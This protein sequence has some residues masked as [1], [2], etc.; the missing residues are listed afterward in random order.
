MNE[1]V[2]EQTKNLDPVIS[3]QDFAL[4]PESTNNFFLH[5]IPNEFG[6]MYRSKK[7]YQRFAAENKDLHQNLLKIFEDFPA[8]IVLGG[9]AGFALSDIETV[10]KNAA[11]RVDF[12]SKHKSE[13]YKAYLAM[14]RFVT[15][16]VEIFR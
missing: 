16:D 6:E 15:S 12:F 10:R 4:T 2:L 3:A 7:Y 14:R 5:F 11:A 13:L 1:R 9:T 8:P